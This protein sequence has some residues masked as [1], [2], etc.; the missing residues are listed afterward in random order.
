M[1]GPQLRDLVTRLTGT[2]RLSVQDPTGKLSCNVLSQPAGKLREV[3]LLNYDFTYDLPGNRVADDDGSGEARSYLSDTNWRM[4]KI[5]AV[6]DPAKFEKPALNILG[7][8]NSRNQLIR[9]VVSLNGKDVATLAAKDIS[10]QLT[11]PLAQADLRAGDNEIILRLE[12]Q[13]NTMSEWYQ[14][15]LDTDATSKRSYFSQDG[16][17]TW[18]QDDLSE[19]RG[20]QTG[21]FIIRLVDSVKTPT[22]AEWE[23]M[24]HVH[25]ATGVR[26]FVAGDQPSAAVALSPT[27]PARAVVA[28][29]VT[30]GFE[31]ALDVGTYAVLVLASDRSALAQWLP[32]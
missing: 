13:P 14:V 23:Q 19:D 15:S 3:H 30:G 17:K 8:L 21:E 12:G 9:L 16:G 31:Y 10:S 5:L 32:K 22:H 26:V 29:K 27:A 4:K 18:K 25:P 1:P 7:S 6:P 28:R 11:I 2:P 20:N 24:C